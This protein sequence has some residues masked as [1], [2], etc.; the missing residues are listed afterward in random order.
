[1][2]YTLRPINDGTTTA[3]REELAA[4]ESCSL[5]QSQHGGGRCQTLH[6]AE[7]TPCTAEHLEQRTYRRQWRKK[8]SLRG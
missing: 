7:Q 8:W 2:S 5:W 4:D 1:M 6:I 3:E